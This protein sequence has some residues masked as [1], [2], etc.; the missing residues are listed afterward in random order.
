MVGESYIVGNLFGSIGYC[1]LS[2]VIDDC[3]L[4]EF[5]CCYVLQVCGIVVIV[6][7]VV[8]SQNGRKICEVNVVFGLFVIDDFYDSVYVGDLDVQVFEVDGSV[9]SFSVLFVLVLEFM[10]F[11]LLCY[12][13]I[14]GQVCQ[15]GDGDD[16]FVDFIYQCGMSNVLIVNLGLCV[17]DD[18]LVML[19][20]GVFVIC[21]GVFGLNSIYFSVCV[22]DGVCKQGWCIGFDYSWI[23]QFIGIILILVGYCYFIEGYCEFGDVFGLCDVLCYGDIWDFGSYK[24]CNQFNLLVSQVF[25][26]YGNFY[27]FGFFSDFYDG[28]SCDI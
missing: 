17:V 28:K 6:V 4:F 11:G 25:G 12:S 14:L 1:G 15:Y 2:L 22:E 10:C 9:L 3:M 27:F 23:F 16:L 7:W 20:G 24:Q 8:I 18:Y 19:G 26:G 13:F 21:F 5:L